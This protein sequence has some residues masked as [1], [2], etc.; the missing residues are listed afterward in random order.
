[1]RIVIVE[2]HPATIE[3][4]KLLLGGEQD[5]TVAG[6]FASAEEAIGEIG[7]LKPDLLLVDLG[8][9]G[10]CGVGFIKAIKS[11]FPEI[12]IMVLTILEDKDIV[13]Q[14]IKNC[15]S[16]Y[17]LKGSSPRELVEAIH[18]IHN[19]GAPMSPKI[20]RKIIMGMRNNPKDEQYILSAREKEVLR[21]REGGFSYK[22]ISNKLNISPHTVHTHIKNI[23][24]KLHAKDGKEALILARKKGII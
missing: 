20:A 22:E 18:N 3:N 16:G 5:I 19:G 21:H 24:E 11:K 15:A 1:M 10:M 2:D 6:A 14:A 7:S 23:Y 8:L 12:E 9:P 13:F 4:L 17:I